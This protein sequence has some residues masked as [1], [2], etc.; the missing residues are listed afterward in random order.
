M[1]NPIRQLAQL[2]G[3]AD[4]YLDFR[5]Q[6]KQVSVE[7]QVAILAA[8][9]VAAGDDTAAQDAIHRFETQRWTA[10]VPPIAVFG[11]GQPM[12]VPI[13]VPVD[14][15]ARK[16]DWSVTLESGE[17]RSGTAQLSK[18]K[19]IEQASVDNRSYRRLA[20]PLPS[21]PFGYHT[22]SFALD[23]GLQGTLRVVV[24]PEQCFEAPAIAAG[25]RLWGIAVQLYSLRADDNW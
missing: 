8:M 10:F 6:P 14:L 9:G 2:H 23:T 18:L 20:V 5:G 1:D 16:V 4:S 25:E 3:I 12:S 21:L 24:T 17:P 22:A 13:A 15:A 7:S 11:E 19:T